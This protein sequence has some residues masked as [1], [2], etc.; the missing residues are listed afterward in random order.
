MAS[1]G[2]A[3]ALEL[4]EIYARAVRIHRPRDGSGSALMERRERVSVFVDRL[5]LTLVAVPSP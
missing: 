1:V 3:V 5:L 4:D 2:F